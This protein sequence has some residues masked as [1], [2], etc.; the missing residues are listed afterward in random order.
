MVSP[1]SFDRLRMI[2]V[3]PSNHHGEPVEPSFDTLKI[4]TQYL[5]INR[6]PL[7]L[8]IGRVARVRA[9]N[10]R[11]HLVCKGDSQCAACAQPC[12]RSDANSS[13]AHWRA[14]FSTTR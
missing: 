5:V 6:K 9:C 4:N 3:S 11:Q 2:M 8:C 10:L 7:Q 13:V 14:V 1:S 12:N